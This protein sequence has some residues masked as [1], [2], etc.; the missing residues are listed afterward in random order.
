MIRH[1]TDEPRRFHL[2]RDGRIVAHGVMWND[3]TA[4][5]RWISDRPS[6]VFWDHGIEDAYAVHTSQLDTRIEWID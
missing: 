1:T 2:N 6:I 4:S 5:V 3:G